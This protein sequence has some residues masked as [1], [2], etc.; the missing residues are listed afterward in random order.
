MVGLAIVVA[1]VEAATVGAA[2]AAVLAVLLVEE[3]SCGMT[4]GSVDMMVLGTTASG[5]GRPQVK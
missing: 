1:T 3:A 2:T 4:V 5:V